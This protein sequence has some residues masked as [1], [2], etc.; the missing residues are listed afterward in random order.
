MSN[1][2]EKIFNSKKVKDDGCSDLISDVDLVTKLSIRANDTSWAYPTIFANSATFLNY[3]SSFNNH[4]ILYGC[5][6][7]HKTSTWQPQL[8]TQ[9]S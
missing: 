9:M 2:V 5:S 7:M 4:R 6:H 8:Q 1:S 3:G